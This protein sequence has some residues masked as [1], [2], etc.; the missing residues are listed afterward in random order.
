MIGVRGSDRAAVRAPASVPQTPALDPA[1]R[2]GRVWVMSCAVTRSWHA[3][4][5][6]SVEVA[7]RA[8]V[9]TKLVDP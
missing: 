9:N 7:T 6:P 1:P 2:A 8:E 5:R 3:V 4:R